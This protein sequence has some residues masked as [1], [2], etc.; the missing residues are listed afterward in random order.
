MKWFRNKDIDHFGSLFFLYCCGAVIL[1]LIKALN[2]LIYWLHK[3]F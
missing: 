2:E 3:T 1:L